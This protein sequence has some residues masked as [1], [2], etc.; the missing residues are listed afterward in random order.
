MVRGM[1]CGWRGE[2]GV[3][4][5]AVCAWVHCGGRQGLGWDHS[6]ECWNEDEAVIQVHCYNGT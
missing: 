6:H 1:V 5:T 2:K 3:T 4:A